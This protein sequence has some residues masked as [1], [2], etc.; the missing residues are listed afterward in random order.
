MFFPSVA[1]ASVPSTCLLP[2]NVHNLH[3][4]PGLARHHL[5]SPLF[6]G[7]M[8][9]GAFSLETSGHGHT[10]VTVPQ[11]VST[12]L[13][14][15]LCMFH[16]FTIG[17]NT[18]LALIVLAVMGLHIERFGMFTDFPHTVIKVSSLDSPNVKFS[19]RAPVRLL[20]LPHLLLLLCSNSSA[21]KA[22]HG[23]GTAYNSLRT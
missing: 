14:H 1:E 22:T 16:T 13:R 9:F 21:P 19:S 7:E 17:F 2:I 8:L 15:K 23:C 12:F 5:H 6:I 3:S 4:L 20:F 10:K 11:N 18:C